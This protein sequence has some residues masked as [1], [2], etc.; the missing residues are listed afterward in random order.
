MAE[1]TKKRFFSTMDLLTMAAVAVVGAVFASFV[2]PASLSWA[3]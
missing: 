1:A 2:W 3:P